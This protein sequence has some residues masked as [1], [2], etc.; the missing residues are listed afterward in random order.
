MKYCSRNIRSPDAWPF[1]KTPTFNVISISVGLS[2]TMMILVILSLLSLT[3]STNAA[4]FPLGGL[5]KTV[6]RPRPVEQPPQ[7]QP[8]PNPKPNNNKPQNDKPQ[9]DKPQNA[10]H[11]DP[12]P[13][14]AQAQ[15][16]N[17]Y[18]LNRRLEQAET[19]LN[20]LD[21]GQSIA[22]ALLATSQTTTASGE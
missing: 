1:F 11:I 5:P 17:V 15:L 18:G 14:Q 10:P 22:E 3:I 13:T 12:A 4:F 16:N 21:I 9:N 7:Q 19:V 20:V 8:H 6:P 2:H